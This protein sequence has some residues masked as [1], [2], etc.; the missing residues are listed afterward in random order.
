[1]YGGMSPPV[2]AARL[3][4]VDAVGGKRFV[5][6]APVVVVHTV[7]ARNLAVPAA[8]ASICVGEHDPVL[9]CESCTHRAHLDARRIV[10]VLARAGEERHRCVWVLPGFRAEHIHPEDGLWCVVF[11]LAGLHAR[12]APLAPLEIDGHCVFRHLLSLQHSDLDVI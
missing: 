5:R 6:R 3:C 8:D 7:R 2:T 10:A 4:V 11:D 1:L 12:S 9:T